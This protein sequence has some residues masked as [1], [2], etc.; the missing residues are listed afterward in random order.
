MNIRINI[1]C[2]FQTPPSGG[3]HNNN[4][5]LAIELEWCGYLNLDSVSCATRVR[6]GMEQYVGGYWTC[7]VSTKTPASGYSRYYAYDS[8]Y[9]L[10]GVCGTY[11]NQDP[12]AA[13]LQIACDSASNYCGNDM[14]C[15]RDFVKASHQN[16]IHDWC[17]TG[18]NSEKFNFLISTT[19]GS[20]AWSGYNGE[21][22]TSQHAFCTG[23]CVNK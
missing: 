20:V 2:T 22:A 17:P 1:Y 10:F 8:Y 13:K 23:Y 12:N 19:S 14:V 15:M 21:I 7:A 5:V 6:E 9:D 4:E 3:S 11:H 18:G 16:G